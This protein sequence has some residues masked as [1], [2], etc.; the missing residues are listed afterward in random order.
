MDVWAAISAVSSAVSTA[1]LL[2]TAF[3]IVLQLREARLARNMNLLLTIHERYHDRE[4][5]G[6]RHKLIKGDYTDLEK[7][8]ESEHL[9]L[10]SLVNESELL[11][12][13]IE[14]KFL[15]AEDVRMFFSWS[16]PPEFG[17]KWQPSCIV[18]D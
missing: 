10:R 17:R 14:K 8:D 2:G 18:G 11:G 4:L 12:L 16:P 7:L 5:S 3:Y 6:F 15:L 13:L 1:V 9:L